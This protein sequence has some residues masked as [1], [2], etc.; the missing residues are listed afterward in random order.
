MVD[1]LVA[2]IYC[3]ERL[4]L[5]IGDWSG[6]TLNFV[7]SKPEEKILKETLSVLWGMGLNYGWREARGGSFFLKS[8]GKRTFRTSGGSNDCLYGLSN[9][10][11]S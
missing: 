10:N 6:S 8:I 5:L 4:L 3:H 9:S 1:L 2:K 7:K 11:S